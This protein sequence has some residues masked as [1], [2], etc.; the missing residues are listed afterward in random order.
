MGT[1][2]SLSL[3]LTVVLV[4]SILPKKTARVNTSFTSLDTLDNRTEGS[5]RLALIGLNVALQNFLRR[6][7]SFPS[8]EVLRRRLPFAL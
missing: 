2:S 5:L 8:N 6:G 7:L 4:N 3:I 1:D